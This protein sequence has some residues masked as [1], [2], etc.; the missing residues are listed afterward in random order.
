MGVINN[1]NYTSWARNTDKCICHWNNNKQKAKGKNSSE[2]P[3]MKAKL[4]YYLVIIQTSKTEI[5]LTLIADLLSEGFE[6]QKQSYVVF[7]FCHL[8][9]FSLCVTHIFYVSSSL[10]K[11]FGSLCHLWIASQDVMDN[12]NCSL[13][14]SIKIDPWFHQKIWWEHFFMLFKFFMADYIV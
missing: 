13:T 11:S 12:S 10:N 6:N 3:S 1:Y 7:S 9:C 2:K 5:L 8:L 14:E 4:I